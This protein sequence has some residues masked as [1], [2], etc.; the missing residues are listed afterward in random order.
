MNALP[1][2]PGMT[3][4]SSLEMSHPLGQELEIFRIWRGIYF[5]EIW[6]Q[7]KTQ[8]PNNWLKY[9][10]PCPSFAKE[11]MK[12]ATRQQENVDNT[13]GRVEAKASETDNHKCREKLSPN[14]PLFK[15]W[16]EDL[17]ETQQ[18]KAQDLFWKFSYNVYLSN[19]LPLNLPIPD[20][21]DSR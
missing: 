13:P 12:L 11:S 10:F 14:S 2:Q 3:L 6:R 5:K 17:S 9:L 20:T 7:G 4:T 1:R 16:G 18:K 19:Q 21:Q 8:V 15:H